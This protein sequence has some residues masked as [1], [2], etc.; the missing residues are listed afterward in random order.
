M[1]NFLLQ[2]KGFFC[3]LSDLVVDIAHATIRGS[4]Y[5]DIISSALNFNPGNVGESIAESPVYT[6][7]M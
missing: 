6:V 7:L 3:S 1:P 5:T 4:I 2:D